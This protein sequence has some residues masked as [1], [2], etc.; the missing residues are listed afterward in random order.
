MLGLEDR[1]SAEPASCPLQSV[2]DLTLSPDA[3]AITR[4]LVATRNNRDFWCGCSRGH[5]KKSHIRGKKARC[6]PVR[7]SPP[8]RHR[9]APRGFRVQSESPPG[10]PRIS[11][12]VDRNRVLNR[13]W[14]F[15]SSTRER[16]SKCLRCPASDRQ[17]L[18]RDALC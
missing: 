10:L 4:W 5:E 11:T 18:R 2:R 13:I 7:R 16:L 3:G 17:G 9:P 8:P 1:R 15:R 6:G 14:W 12:G